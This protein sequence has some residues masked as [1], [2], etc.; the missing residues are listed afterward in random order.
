MQMQK[1]D[2]SHNRYH[3]SIDAGRHLYREHGLKSLYVG[4]YPTFLREILGLSVYFGS[5]EAGM[6]LLSKGENSAEA[7]ILGAFLA[8]GI[9]GSASWFFTY[10]IDYVKTLMQSQLPTEQ[11]FTSGID[12]MIKQYKA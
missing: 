7:P 11:K 9:A 1:G 10:P 8:G 4:F 5:Y 3:S 6:R 2:D 12:C